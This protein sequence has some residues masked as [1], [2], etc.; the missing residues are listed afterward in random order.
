MLHVQRRLRVLRALALVPAVA[1]VAAVASAPTEIAHAAMR[2]PPR[3]GYH[4]ART[5]P[6]RDPVNG[7]RCTV[8]G[9]RCGYGP[10]QGYAYARDF[11]CVPTAG[12][13]ALTWS[14]RMPPPVGN[15]SAD[16]DP[17]VT[18][19]PLPPPELHANADRGTRDDADC[20]TGHV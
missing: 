5:C 3:H 12:T 9:A 13:D 11:T 4:N 17:G 2:A 20:V 1:G 15:S 6:R 18:R 14:R 16:R 7:A 8:Q 19:G 10:W